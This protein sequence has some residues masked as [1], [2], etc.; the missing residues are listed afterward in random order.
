MRA[1]TGFE[2]NLGN[3]RVRYRFVKDFISYDFQ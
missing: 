3:E 1:S 2:P